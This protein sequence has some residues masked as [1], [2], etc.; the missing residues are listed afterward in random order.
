MGGRSWWRCKYMHYAF[1]PEHELFN[2]IMAVPC[3]YTYIGVGFYPR[4]RE[5]DHE[6]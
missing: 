2:K 3:S 4:E 5:W 6:Y 1:Y